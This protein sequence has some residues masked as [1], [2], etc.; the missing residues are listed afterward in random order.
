MEGNAKRGVEPRGHGTSGGRGRPGRPW[1]S[2]A[3]CSAQPLAQFAQQT[4]SLLTAALE[5]L[6]RERRERSWSR[7]FRWR[8][9]TQSDPADGEI[10]LEAVGLKEVGELEGADIAAAGP[11]L[12]LEVGDE[13]TEVV[14]GVTGAQEF[15]P[16]S[17]AVVAE[18]ETLAGERTVEVVGVADGGRL[19]RSGR[20]HV[21]E[22]GSGPVAEVG[23]GR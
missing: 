13:M 16:Q 17:F 10:F 21:Q 19:G 22:A 11:D 15:E 23:A 18:A 14:E 7:W 4:E 8:W 20:G 5:F 9:R 3:V 2:S 1:T 6:G 12:A